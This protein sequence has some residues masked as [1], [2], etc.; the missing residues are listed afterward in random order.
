MPTKK[1]PTTDPLVKELKEIRQL[2]IRQNTYR[3]RFFK[4]VVGGIGT[5]LGATIFAGI[6]AYF[7]SQ[8]LSGFIETTNLEKIS[9][10]LIQEFQREALED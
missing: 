9:P 7:I 5:V 4:G 1:K 3:R 8:V 6:A 10:E 2:M